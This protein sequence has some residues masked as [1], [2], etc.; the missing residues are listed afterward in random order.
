MATPNI[1]SINGSEQ[2]QR[3]NLI[4]ELCIKDSLLDILHNRNNDP[5]YVGLPE[6]RV[7]LY[8]RM[9]AFK[10]AHEKALRKV[11]RPNQWDIICPKSRSSDSNDWDI[12]II[13]VVIQYEKLLPPPI[14]GWELASPA[15]S[16][17]RKAAHICRAKNIRNE[18]K[19]GTIKDMCDVNKY[20]DLLSRIERALLGMNYKNMALFN[21]LK[22]CSLMVYTPQTVKILQERLSDLRDEL[23]NVKIDANDFR[24]TTSGNIS[25]INHSIQKNCNDMVEKLRILKNDFLQK[26]QKNCQLVTDYVK[27]YDE[28]KGQIKQMETRIVGIEE[29][30][31]RNEQR[32]NEHEKRLEQ[33]ESKT[34]RHELGLSSYNLLF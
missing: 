23:T 34:A 28:L 11:I 10:T 24:N 22:H 19:H 14:G 13:K 20:N 33:Y 32:I 16:D 25:H 12:P 7:L 18:L 17:T 2:W 31:D 26:D 30:S 21:E 9:K 1:T 4:G 27:K 3:I 5:S 29:K 6:N 15:N 8:Q